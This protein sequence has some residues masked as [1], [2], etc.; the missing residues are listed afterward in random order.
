MVALQKGELAF[1]S[2]WESG[3]HK[4]SDFNAVE[5]LLVDAVVKLDK[6][7]SKVYAFDLFINNIDRHWWNFLFRQSYQGVIALAFGY[8]RAWLEV[9][10]A[11]DTL[12]EISAIDISTIKQILLEIPKEWMTKQQI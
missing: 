6:F 11:E 1:G 9:K 12:N 10:Y 3:V 8:S 4:I 2:V 7:F 5:S